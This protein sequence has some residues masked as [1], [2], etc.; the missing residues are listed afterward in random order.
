MVKHMFCIHKIIGSS[1]IISKSS[2]FNV[3]N[4]MRLKYQY[5]FIDK[6]DSLETN[7]SVKK[8]SILF[9]QTPIKIYNN[10]EKTFKTNARK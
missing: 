6:L 4:L 2:N 10:F 1:P 9:V 3:E 7:L 5:D 8:N